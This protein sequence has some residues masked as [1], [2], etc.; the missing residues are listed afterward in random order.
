MSNYLEHLHAKWNTLRKNTLKGF[1]WA[2]WQFGKSAES[3]IIWQFCSYENKESFKLV[4]L[5]QCEVWRQTGTK[6]DLRSAVLMLFWTGGGFWGVVECWEVLDRLLHFGGRREKTQISNANLT[7]EMC[8]GSVLSWD[9]DTGLCTQLCQGDCRIL[10]SCMTFASWVSVFPPPVVQTCFG[11]IWVYNS[12]LH[13]RLQPSFLY[14]LQ[15]A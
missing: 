6:L 15:Y 13:K 14:M 7:G 8:L 2:I 5:Q 12:A 3:L 4:L 10:G 11:T 1:C 9:K